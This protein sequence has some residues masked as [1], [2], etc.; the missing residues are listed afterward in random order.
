MIPNILTCQT[1]VILTIKDAR[2]VCVYPYNLLSILIEL[3]LP[4]KLQNFVTNNYVF[5]EK[6]VKTQ[7]ENK[8]IKHKNP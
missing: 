1:V 6:K 7:Q 5:G 2:S 3:T 4:K 8:Q